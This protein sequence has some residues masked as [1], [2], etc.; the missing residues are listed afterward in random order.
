M[1]LLWKHHPFVAVTLNQR[2]SYFV[3]RCNEMRLHAGETLVNVL[4]FKKDMGLWHGVLTVSDNMWTCHQCYYYTF[5]QISASNIT[6]IRD[7]PI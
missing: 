7:A 6:M 2:T 4:D 3:W 1:L 5:I